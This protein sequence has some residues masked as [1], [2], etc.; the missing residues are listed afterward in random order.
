M[1]LRAEP[2]PV[3][4]AG[5]V[6]DSDDS[7]GSYES[8]FRSTGEL[9]AATAH[10][11]SID[12]VL[13]GIESE[14]VDP[15]DSRYLSFVQ[16]AD[17]QARWQRPQV[18]RALA[19]GASA[20]LLLLVVQLAIGARD[21]LASRWPST[22][23]LLSALCT[24]LGCRVEPLRRIERLAV[25]SSGLTRVADGSPVYR[26]AMVLRN[27]GDVPLLLPAVDLSLTDSG[28]ALVTRRVLSAADLGATRTIIAPGQELPLQALL[29]SAER[30]VTGYTIEIF[31]P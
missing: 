3:K 31:Y 27:R 15:G 19:A 14:V 24:P 25:E 29:M 30:P 10:P 16:Q 2:L 28:G 8:L 18:R 13:D 20:L 11:S 4:S 22:E 23:P 7:A 6:A 5:D 26:L 21:L 9:D 17:Q 12:I 1:A